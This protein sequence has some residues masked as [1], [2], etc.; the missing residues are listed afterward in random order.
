MFHLH[1]TNTV[2]AAADNKKATILVD[3][4]NHDILIGRLESQF[5]VCGGVCSWLRLYLTGRQQFVKVGDHSSATTQCVSGVP[6]GSVLS[7]LLFAA[8]VSPVGDLIESDGVLYHQFAD[9]TQLLITMNV[10]DASPAPKR[11]AACS[12]ALRLRFLQN[13][14][15][16]NS[17]K[18]EVVILGTA[19]QLR[20]AAVI[21]VVD[22]ADGRLQVAPKLKSL[23][24]AID[25]HLWFDYHVRNVARACSYHTRTLRHVRSLLT[26]D[27]A[28]T[29][30]CSIQT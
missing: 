27:L 28:Q 29:V 10:N 1:V 2:N 14:L 20:S 22:V 9:D 11:L 18:S 19:P 30:A 8:Y 15:L 7:P 13:D 16:L 26:N 17:D 3:T 21:R 6:H 24:V 12:A 23:G 5:G 25:S 4:T